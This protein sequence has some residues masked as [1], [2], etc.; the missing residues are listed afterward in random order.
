[1]GSDIFLDKNDTFL[2]CCLCV[3]HKMWE[4]CGL[5]TVEEVPPWRDLTLFQQGFR[6][7]GPRCSE[8]RDIF[9]RLYLPLFKTA[10]VWSVALVAHWG[11]LVLIIQTDRPLG[12]LMLR[13]YLTSLGSTVLWIT[14][15]EMRRSC[16]NAPLV[17]VCWEVS[18]CI[19]CISVALEW[20]WAQDQFR[21]HLLN[22][23]HSFFKH[24]IL[25]VLLYKTF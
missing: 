24:L 11:E 1:M 20:M 7:A 8:Q 15:Q 21:K 25:T 18:T 2:F 9:V 6:G 23:S 14:L 4:G 22:W 13:D 17:C 12:E 16:F 19:T 10:K 3:L 5:R